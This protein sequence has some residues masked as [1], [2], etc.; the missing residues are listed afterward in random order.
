MIS[1]LQYTKGINYAL[2]EELHPELVSILDDNDITISKKMNNFKK[3]IKDLSD[4]N[5]DTGLE[6]LKAKKGSSRA[7]YFPK[8]SEKIHLDGQETSIPIALKIAIVNPLDRHTGDDSTL[9]EKQNK[10]ESD[11]FT[12]YRYGKIYRDDSGNLHTNE[13]GILAPV[14]DNHIKDHYIKMAKVDNITPKIFAKLTINEK[15]P[16][17]IKFDDFVDTLIKNH[18]RNGGKK[19]KVDEHI[20]NHPLT[21]TFAN[22]IADTVND[23]RDYSIVNFGVFTHPIT[24]KKSVVL[25]DFGADEDVMHSYTKARKIAF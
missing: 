24:K 18:L 5:L 25:R 11:S 21:A 6:S 14:I 10:N 4:R 19:V 13:E 17:G 15:Y 9:G 12:N 3:K 16:N 2:Y 20:L 1:F 7:V 23:P 22:F 8:D